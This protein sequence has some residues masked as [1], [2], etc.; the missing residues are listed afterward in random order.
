MKRSLQ[1]SKPSACI[2][3]FSQLPLSVSPV[4]VPLPGRT[5]GRRPPRELPRRHHPRPRIGYTKKCVLLE[6][7]SIYSHIIK[8]TPD[9]SAQHSKKTHLVASNSVRGP[10]PGQTPGHRRPPPRERPRRPGSHG[11]A[12]SARS[13]PLLSDVDEGKAEDMATQ[14]VRTLC[15]SE[16]SRT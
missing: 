14:P 3:P 9:V 4:R 11:P 16:F 7:P 12:P 5:P 1:E 15:L 8:S 2:L 6:T 10:P 13:Q